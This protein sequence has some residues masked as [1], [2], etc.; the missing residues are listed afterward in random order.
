MK[1]FIVLGIVFCCSMI[2]LGFAN[3][4]RKKRIFYSEV[5]LLINNIKNEINFS[6]KN[7]KEILKNIRLKTD[8][9]L[10]VKDF[11]LFI[12]TKKDFHKSIQNI[13]FLD[14]EEKNNLKNLFESLGRYNVETQLNDLENHKELFA[15]FFQLSVETEKKNYSLCIKLGVI[16]GALIS[17]I[18]I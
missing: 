10:I 16:F 5:L 8:L 15:R 7:I 11:I 1:I 2:G 17:L 9:E 6:N 14:L 12:E 13:S 4:Y 3:F 18:I